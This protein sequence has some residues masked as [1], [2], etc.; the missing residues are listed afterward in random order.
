MKHRAKCTNCLSQILNTYSYKKHPLIREG[1]EVYIEVKT[2]YEAYLIESLNRTFTEA[3][4]IYQNI[5]QRHQ[6]QTKI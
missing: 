4:H 2:Q 5:T 1:D 6:K 3:L